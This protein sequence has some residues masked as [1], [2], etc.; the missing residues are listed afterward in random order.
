M[1]TPSSEKSDW[2][3][4]GKNAGP[5]AGETA[6]LAARARGQ[7]LLVA[8]QTRLLFTHCRAGLGGTL[9]VAIAMAFLFF[10]QVPYPTLGAWLLSVLL[11]LLWRLV[12]I[13]R[14][15]RA[16]PDDD[17]LGVWKQ[18]FLVGSTLSAILMGSSIWLV[19]LHGGG[20]ESHVLLAFMLGGMCLAAVSLL[21][22]ALLVYNVYVC[23]LCLPLVSWFWLQG[24]PLYNVM[25][26]L[27]LVFLLAMIATGHGH[28]RTLMRLLDLTAAN[29][30]L[31]EHQRRLHDFADMGADCFWES[32]D[33]GRF[34]FLSE[35]YRQLTGLSPRQMI[36]RALDDPSGPCLVPDRYLRQAAAGIGIDAASLDPFH[37]HAIVWKH[38][39][40][41]TA[42]LLSNGLPVLG[43]DGRLEG[44]RGTVRDITEQHRLAEK[45][46]YQATHDAL[47]ELVN[48]REFERRLQ[49]MI[50]NAA[51]TG[52]VHAVCYLDL[53][54]F[55]VVND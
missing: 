27:G 54:Q 22:G 39:D 35:G 4:A 38:R 50:D 25:A 46:T 40:G 12:L 18:R 34:T 42:V 32:D 43:A 26:A 45:L 36:G 37:D 29:R 48:R 20:L 11:V 6:S 41:S 28:H 3:N 44:F 31:R 2:R 1:I 47:T 19:G 7:G 14:F 33:Q 49:V 52:A 23:A 51:Q 15:Q 17:E 9:A 5:G 13:W 30:E 53:D 24:T 8:Q 16:A 21:G 55:K 10:E